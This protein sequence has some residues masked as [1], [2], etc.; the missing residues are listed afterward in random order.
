[1]EVAK[2]LDALQPLD[3]EELVLFVDGYDTIIT[4][5]AAS[6]ESEYRR[7]CPEATL[8]FFGREH[9]YEHSTWLF[10]MLTEVFRR[11]HCVGQDLPIVNS[12]V[13]LGPVRVLKRVCHAMIAEGEAS[14]EKDDQR[15]LN[16]LIAKH[17]HDPNT[18]ISVG[19][20]EGLHCHC[21]RS[22][23]GPLR[24]LFTNV[25]HVPP[26]PLHYDDSYGGFEEWMQP[27]ASPS[28]CATRA[29]SS[30]RFM[31]ATASFRRTSVPCAM[32]WAS[33]VRRQPTSP[34]ARF[35]KTIFAPWSKRRA[36]PCVR[37]APSF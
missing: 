20:M 26:G 11:Y 25:P 4:A 31:F 21:E 9:R 28:R 1:M 5:D 10:W 32:P 3:D 17:A 27:P 35:R 22:L 30:T 29:A 12:G 8:A 33:S 7:R 37:F 34:S 2:L 14:G 23:L 13:A 19:L 36:R 15:V 18:G 24:H 16:T 6:L